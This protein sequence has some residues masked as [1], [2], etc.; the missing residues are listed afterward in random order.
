MCHHLKKPFA[1]E[2]ETNTNEINDSP[3]SATLY[4][5]MFSYFYSTPVCSV[6]L[7]PP[8]IIRKLNFEPHSFQTLPLASREST[9]SRSR[10]T[11]S[12]SARPSSVAAKQVK[13]ED[14]SR[15]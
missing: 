14:K 9:Y 8:K 13:T 1:S 2:L 5:F 7:T 12:K 3:V 6:T 4:T 15:L 11:D 10:T